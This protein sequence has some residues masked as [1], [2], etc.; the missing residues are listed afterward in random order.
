MT[1]DNA[2][3]KADPPDSFMWFVVKGYNYNQRDEAGTKKPR[4]DGKIGRHCCE[5]TTSPLQLRV[6]I[7]AL[8]GL[9]CAYSV[10]TNWRL[11]EYVS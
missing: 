7:C 11:A 10:L 5:K 9:S 1:Y 2:D 3:A 4:D 6:A 8:E